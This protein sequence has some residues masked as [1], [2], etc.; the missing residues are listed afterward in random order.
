MPGKMCANLRL[1]K[2][3]KNGLQIFKM[4]K[5]IIRAKTPF[6]DAAADFPASN[7]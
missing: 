3:K 6:L 2:L 5:K 4:R 7:T 1:Y